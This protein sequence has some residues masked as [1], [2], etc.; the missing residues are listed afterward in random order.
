VHELCASLLG[1]PEHLV[2]DALLT[3][4]VTLQAHQQQALQT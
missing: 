1:N 4:R 3:S 2:R